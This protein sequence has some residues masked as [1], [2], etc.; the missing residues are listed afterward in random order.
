LSWDN[1]PVW[2]TRLTAAAQQ[3]QIPIQFTQT[4]NEGPPANPIAPIVKQF[5]A[6]NGSGN[7]DVA[8]SMFSNVTGATSQKNAHIK[9]MFDK[10][11]VKRCLWW[12]TSSPGMVCSECWAQASLW[13]PRLERSAP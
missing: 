6:A 11:E 2:A 7:G 4:F 1:D 12:P 5:L 8:A 10:V 3:H 9:F 13:P